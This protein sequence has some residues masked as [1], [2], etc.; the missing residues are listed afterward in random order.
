MILPTLVLSISPALQAGA[1]PNPNKNAFLVYA[2]QTTVRLQDSH[3]P[4]PNDET[5]RLQLAC[6]TYIQGF[7]DSAALTQG[8][9]VKGVSVGMLTKGYLAFMERHPEMLEQH[10]ALGLAASIREAHACPTK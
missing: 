7:A 2:C 5:T 6:V 8:L 4:S 1:Q 10:K 3:I 9:C